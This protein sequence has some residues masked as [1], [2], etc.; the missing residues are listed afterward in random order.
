MADNLHI[1]TPL[2]EVRAS[3]WIAILAVL[4]LGL[5]VFTGRYMNLW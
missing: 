2:F 1:K 4:L 5:G 3:G